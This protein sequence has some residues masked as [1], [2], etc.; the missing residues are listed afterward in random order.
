MDLGKIK[1]NSGRVERVNSR[2][3]AYF[4]DGLDI[5]RKSTFEHSEW[6]CQLKAYKQAPLTSM[7]RKEDSTL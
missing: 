7:E 3:D 2:V 5:L 1:R 6:C 4:L